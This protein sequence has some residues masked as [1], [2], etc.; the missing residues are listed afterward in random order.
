MCQRAVVAVLFLALPAMAAE[1]THTVVPEDCFTL[2]GITE[3]AVSPDGKQVAFAEARWSK[4]DDA[5]KADL[6]VIATDGQSK[7]QRLTFDRGGD[8]HIRW[9]ADGKT[10]YFLGSR[11]RRAETKAALR[12]QAASVGDSGGRR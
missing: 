1:R 7:P 8:H 3:V 10:I 11:K 2:A 12:R 4:D 5:R 6:W 9:S